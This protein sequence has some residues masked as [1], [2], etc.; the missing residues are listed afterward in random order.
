MVHLYCAIGIDEF[1]LIQDVLL[2]DWSGCL[3][4]IPESLGE[5]HHLQYGTGEHS[6]DSRKILGSIVLTATSDQGSFI[7]VR[8]LILE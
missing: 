2:P 7:N 6:S 8:H 5:C 3:E 1:K 4:P